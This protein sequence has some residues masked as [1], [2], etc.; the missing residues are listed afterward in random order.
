MIQGV[1]LHP[2]FPRTTVIASKVCEGLTE[3]WALSRNCPIPPMTE[4]STIDP[5][6][7]DE[8]TEAALSAFCL[9]SMVMSRVA[10]VIFSPEGLWKLLFRYRM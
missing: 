7:T 10:C 8:E 2:G 6:C 9:W 3:Q 5:N 1:V 4:G